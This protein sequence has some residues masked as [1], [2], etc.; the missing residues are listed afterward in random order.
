MTA[1]RGRWLVGTAVAL[2]MLLFAGQ[3][4]ADLGECGC[5]RGRQTQQH[6]CFGTES[7]SEALRGQ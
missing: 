1:V 2:V 6:G 7:R 5:E 3:W 4:L